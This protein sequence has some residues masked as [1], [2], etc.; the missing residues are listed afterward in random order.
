MVLFK[1]QAD[2]QILGWVWT[3]KKE[4]RKEEKPWIQF[5][6]GHPI[7]HYPLMIQFGHFCKK[8][9]ELHK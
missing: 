4:G 8:Y 2:M 9:K 6:T 7:R 3:T 1:V 5:I